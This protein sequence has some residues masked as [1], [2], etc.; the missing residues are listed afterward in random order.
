MRT[1]FDFFFGVIALIGGMLFLLFIFIPTMVW[2]FLRDNDRA[3]YEAAF[4]SDS[5]DPELKNSLFSPKDFIT[6]TTIK[7]FENSYK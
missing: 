5:E 6:Q 3:A 7:Y 4:K 2:W 1:I